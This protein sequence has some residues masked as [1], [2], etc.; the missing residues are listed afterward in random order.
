MTRASD[1]NGTAIRESDRDESAVRE[2]DCNDPAIRESD[3]D[4]SV[5]RESDRDDTQRFATQS[6]GC[7]DSQKT[8]TM[9]PRFAR[10]IAMVP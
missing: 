3:R 10:A 5:I 9:M 6:H 8:I 2:S 1:R 4:D 7:R